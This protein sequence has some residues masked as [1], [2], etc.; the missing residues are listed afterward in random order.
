[1]ATSSWLVAGVIFFA[2]MTVFAIANASTLVVGPELF[3]RRVRYT[4]LAAAINLGTVV[5]GGTAPFVAQ[6]L[7][8]STGDPKAPAWWVIVT[9]LI[10]VTG[11]LTMRET[12]HDKLPV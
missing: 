4:A 10:A 6:W 7:V 2:Y 5:A 11:A 8:H 3:P 1:S 9:G 12:S